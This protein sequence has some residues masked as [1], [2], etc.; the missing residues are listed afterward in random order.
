MKILITGGSGFIGRNLSEGL[1]EKYEV[2]A[3]THSQLEL[4]NDEAI[5]NFLKK[6]QVD[7]IIHAA[8]CP[9]HRNAKTPANQLF[10]N[11]RMFF[12]LARN[13]NLFQKMI[14]LSSGLVYDQRYYQPKMREEYFNEHVPIDEGGFSKYIIAK[15]IE[16]SDKIIELRIFGIFGKYEDYSIRFISN[17]ICK[18][19]FDLPLTMKQNRKFDYIYI[20]DLIPIVDYFINNRAKFRAYNVTPDKSVE[21]STLAEK[22]KRISG[23]NLPIIIAKSGMGVE[24]SGE[25]FRLR[26]EIGDIQF[27]PIDQ[28]I[29][30]LYEWYAKN[31]N[32]IDRNGLMVDK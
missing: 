17:M 30:E 7:I 26:Q 31:Q 28:A 11:C 3:P 13:S 15:Y 1:S 20:N 24:Y 29:G 32:M 6:S 21:L 18:T 27:M 22:V 8:V 25:D 23:K 19:L 14:I 12:N 9:G 16:N 5:Q 10:N 2:L 4:L